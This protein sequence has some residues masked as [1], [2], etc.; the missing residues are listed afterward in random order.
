MTRLRDGIE[1]YLKRSYVVLLRGLRAFARAAGLLSWL[2]ARAGSRIHLWLR[3]LFAIHDIDD[4]ASID[5]PWWTLE[6]SC[7]VEVFLRRK[8]GA[9]VFE[10]GSGAST[11]WL[12]KRAGEVHSVEHDPTWSVIVE[13]RLEGHVNVTLHHAPAPFSDDPG[14][15]HSA[16]RRW[17]GADFRDYVLT[18]ERLGGVFDLIVIDGRCRAA[19]LEKAVA[20][21]KDDGVILFDNSR[22]K[23]Y[24]AAIAGSELARLETR[25][26]TACLPYPDTTTLLA[27]RPEALRALEETNA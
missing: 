9:R 8:T 17:R 25:G 5:L 21:L 1:G 14:A 13:R 3:S 27:R 26:L 18:I 23:R 20:Y 16:K 7:L 6:G 22:R 19:C 11:L 10:Y 12:G 4:L 15:L 2:E 24:R